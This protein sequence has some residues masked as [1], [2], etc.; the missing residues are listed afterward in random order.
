V[1][2][3]KKKKKEDFEHKIKIFYLCIP[4]SKLSAFSLLGGMWNFNMEL[5]TTPG[6]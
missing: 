5:M 1:G 4:F 3:F 6:I 2:G